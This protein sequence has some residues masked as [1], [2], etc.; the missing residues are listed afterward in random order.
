MAIHGGERS[1]S[2]FGCFAYGKNHLY[3]S[4]SVWVD[5]RAPQDVLKKTK[6]KH[7]SNFLKFWQ[8]FNVRHESFTLVWACRVNGRKQNSP[9]PLQNIKYEFGNNKAERGRPRN[10]WQDEVR[11][12]GRLVG[13]TGRGERVTQQRGMEG[14]AENGNERSHSARG[15]KWMNEWTNC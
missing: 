2:S 5:P 8:L 6:T 11:K 14:A 9:P 4:I 1:A 10:R 7:L 13:G 12:D 15:N 3:P